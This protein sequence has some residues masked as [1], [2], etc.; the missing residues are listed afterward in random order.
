MDRNES[1]PE[2]RPDK[3]RGKNRA[4]ETPMR[5]KDNMRT[6]AEVLVDQLRIH[7]VRHVFCVPGESY[8]AVL[9]AFHDSDLAVTVCRQEGGACM[10]AEAIGKVTGRRASASSPAGPAPPTLRT[11]SISR[12]RIRR[13]WSCSSARWRATC[14]SAR[15]S[16]K[17]TTAPISAR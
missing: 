5:A 11:A 4:K 7:G 9:D 2:I 14:A 10:M 12:S 8:L 15:P 16:K 1:T 6:A 13:R 17:S 3:G